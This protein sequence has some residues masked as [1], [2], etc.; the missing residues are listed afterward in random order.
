MAEVKIA[1]IKK[2]REMTGAGMMDCKNALEEANLDFDRA[3]ELIRERGKAIANKRA[4][5][6]ASEGVVLAATSKCG[7]AGAIVALNCETDFVAKNADFI[8]LAQKIL[9]AA[10]EAGTKDLEVLKELVI[11]G[12]KVSEL[13]T[14][15]SGITG[16]KMQLSYF[17]RVDAPLV[18]SY[19]HPGNKLA[20]VVGVNKKDANP[21]LVREIAIQ[22]AGMNPVAIDANSLPE[23]IRKR[24]FEIGKEQARLEGKPEQIL[25]KIAEGRLQK[26]I[27]ENVLM[28]QEF[29]VKDT[30][31][32]VEQYLAK[33]DKELK[34]VAMQRY[35]LVD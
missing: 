33:V 28:Q 8:G 15:R 32:S 21:E 30:K 6:E 31:D 29:F 17:A 10:L 3:V 13:V 35:T 22:V 23:E 14:E 12:R 5:R 18:A 11:E 26:F 16:E 34:V 27:K 24:E 2:L 19:I 20:T 9:N 4:D 7:C 25:E 1:D